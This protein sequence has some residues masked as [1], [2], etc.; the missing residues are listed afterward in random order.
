MLNQPDDL[1]NVRQAAQQC[2]R[3]AETIRRW[4]W[5]GKL[6]AQKLGNQL[7]IK[8][9]DLANFCRETAVKY[10]ADIESGME[11]CRGSDIINKE[12]E[13]IVNQRGEY[14]RD[15]ETIETKDFLEAAI[16]FRKKLRNRGYPG[17]DAGTLVRNSREGRIGELRQGLR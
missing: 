2:S 1:L 6:H 13:R 17:I 9:K 3:N 14:M 7:F 11:P 4:I 15:T 10:R 5:D 16:L 12:I 8:N